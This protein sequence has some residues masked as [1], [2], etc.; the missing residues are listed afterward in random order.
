MNH[1]R[2]GGAVALVPMP[3]MQMTPTG[4][5]PRHS[6]V[7]W[8]L[9]TLLAAAVGALVV[10][11]STE[12]AGRAVAE[13]DAREAKAAAE[14]AEKE[15]ETALANALEAKTVA[16]RTEQKWQEADR[17]RTEAEAKRVAAETEAQKARNEVR[18]SKSE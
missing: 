7:P 4:Q 17:Q 13:S 10:V 5:P 18:E 11:F 12:K 1:G 16:T 9:A 8:L 15:R 3:D 14:Q 6:P 2:G